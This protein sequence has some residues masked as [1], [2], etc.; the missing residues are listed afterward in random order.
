MLKVEYIPK[1][2][3]DLQYLQVYLSANRGE[4]TANRIVKKITSEI[5]RLELYP[6][7]GAN[8]GKTINI[9]T[10][11]RYIC[12]EK[13]YV[14]YRLEFDKILIIR[15]INERQNYLKQLFGVSADREETD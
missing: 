8:L 12:S 4:N 6:F 13:N 10:D 15:V 5:R 1:A 7:S 3:E 9:T 2:L 14:F 11:Y